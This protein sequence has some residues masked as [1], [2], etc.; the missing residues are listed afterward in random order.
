MFQN[1]LKTAVALLSITA[2]SLASN[3]GEASAQR[4]FTAP[5][6]NIA[7]FLPKTWVKTGI[8]GEADQKAF[9]KIT[10]DQPYVMKFKWGTDSKLAEQG[11]WRLYRKF[12]VKLGNKWTSKKQSLAMGHAGFGKGGQFSIDLKKYLPSKP[13]KKGSARYYVEVVPR[14]KMK[15][16]K[17]SANSPGQAGA[18]IPA[19]QLGFWS[20]PVVIT[21]AKS[22]TPGT[23]FNFPEVYRKAT[24]C[25][26]RFVLVDD[27]A[28]PGEEEYHISAFVQELFRTPETGS[29]F[30]RPG[31]QQNFGTTYKVMNPPKWRSFA[32][33][34]NGK[35]TKWCRSYVL[36]NKKKNWPRKF[37]L[38]TSIM[39]E[40]AGDE[41]NGWK[42]DV[43]SLRKVFKNHEVYKLATNK[44]EGYL[45]KHGLQ[46]AEYFL[47]GASS[48]ISAA[49]S[50]SAIP[51]VGTAVA[52]AAI[53]IGAIIVDMDDDYY[54]M[55]AAI[56]TLPSNRVDEIRKL[57]GK[58]VGKGKNER[59]VLKQDTLEFW[60]P[61]P[62][63]GGSANGIDGVVQVKIRW[64]FSQRE[65]E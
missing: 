52:I 38:T 25:L 49:T 59:Y 63:I 4:K 44:V 65:L 55:N 27:Q 31:R 2:V 13:P 24:V 12:P 35:M 58:V 34:K 57:P 14:T 60:G 6:K 50:S 18:K 8:F 48:V 3:S 41:I 21:Y 54:G 51:V 64:T 33:K 7:K 19:K 32:F 47:N 56:L 62:A 45:K 16:D 43:K 23:V 40:D 61:P 9:T 46:A 36:G 5:I 20:P 37:V 29:K 53:A 26:D 10:I 11:S 17:T 15:I 1:G 39:E 22:T 28:G 30:N 42:S